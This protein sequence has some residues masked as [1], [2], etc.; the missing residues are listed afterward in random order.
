MFATA[1]PP[2]ESARRHGENR[3]WELSRKAFRLGRSIGSLFYLISLGLT[4][5]WVIAV[6][7]GI[8]L[9]F[10]VPRPAKLASSSPLESSNSSVLST[11]T[12][13]LLQST[14]KLNWLSMPQ[15]SGS[16]QLGGAV[17]AGNARA[18]AEPAGQ[19][20][21]E[22]NWRSAITD[23]VPPHKVDEAPVDHVLRPAPVIAVT[24]SDAPEPLAK[25]LAREPF[26]SPGPGGTSHS[27]SSRKKPSQK[28]AGGRSSAPHP[29]TQA[30]EDVLHKHSHLIK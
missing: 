9:F 15:S 3:A 20:T 6:F 8:G 29:P 27:P 26:G 11:E 21:V 16:P 7:F 18:A 23:P 22:Q 5:T 2:A 24:T 25:E 30:I 4:A 17:A 19:E 13:W 10:L 14:N 28:P 1:D 12:P